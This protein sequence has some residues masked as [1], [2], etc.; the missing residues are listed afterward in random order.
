M[1]LY[2]E[3]ASPGFMTQFVLT[4]AC[5]C[6]F[7]LYGFE[8]GAL[9]N[10]QGHKAFQSQFGYPSGSYL[11]IIV[12]IYNLG[13]FFGCLANIAYGDRLGRKRAIWVGFIFVITGVILQ[14]SSF[15]VVQLFIGRFISGVGTGI[16][17][18]TAPMYQ[19]EV[20][21]AKYRGRLVSAEPMFVAV[22]I[23]LTYWLGYGIGHAEGG[24]V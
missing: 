13:S 7:I 11:G 3:V 6:C 22:G 15:S 2:Y 21:S 9:A 18:S 24:V 5:V 17:T 4:T 14:T 1:K 16:E 23:V 12:S 8:Q 19:A 10:I 20:C